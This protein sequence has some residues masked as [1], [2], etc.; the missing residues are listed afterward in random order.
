MGEGYCSCLMDDAAAGAVPDGGEYV[1]TG[2]ST[3]DQDI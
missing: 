2:V 3:S 1:G